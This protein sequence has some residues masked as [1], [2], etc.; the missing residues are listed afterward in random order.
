MVM[1]MKKIIVTLALT[2][3]FSASSLLVTDRERAVKP[4]SIVKSDKVLLQKLD[5]AQIA[6]GDS[7]RIWCDVFPDICRSSFI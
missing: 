4:A 3:I 5:A 2:Y 1:K 7:S 6:S